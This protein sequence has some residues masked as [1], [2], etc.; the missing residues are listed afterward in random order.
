MTGESP[1]SSITI[2]W[3]VSVC[4]L[5]LP[6]S[7]PQAG[8]EGV[9]ITVSASPD[10]VAPDADATSRRI[11]AQAHFAAGATL[12]AQGAF[13]KALEAYQRA[14][15]AD[16]VDPHL[17]T[18]I[19]EKYI[20][21]Q[22]FK[23]AYSILRTTT[24][25]EAAPAKSFELLGMMQLARGEESPSVE[26]FRKALDLDATLILARQSLVDSH[27]REKREEAA[28][29]L[30]SAAVKV[31]TYELDDMSAL[32]GLYLKYTALRPPRVDSLAH[33]LESLLIK[34]SEVAEDYPVLGV[35]IADILMLMGRFKE[36]ETRLR[37]L[38]GFQ[39][40]IPMIR[41]KLVDLFLRQG[42]PDMAVIELVELTEINPD[43]PRPHFLLGSLKADL[44]QAG[45]A[46]RHYRKAMEVQP[47]FPAPYYELAALQLNQGNA[48]EALLVLQQAR[49]QFPKNFVLEFYSGLAMAS[50]HRYTAALRSLRQAEELAQKDDP[51]RLNGFFYFRIGSTL[52]RLGRLE[53]AETAFLQCLQKTPN[54]ATALNYLGYMWAEKGQKLD[55]AQAWIEKAFTMEPESEAILDSMGWVLFQQGKASE[56]LPFLEKAQKKLKEADPTILDHLGDVYK[57][58]E[59][60]E[61]ARISYQRSLE[62]EFN[63]KVFD[64]W[65]S[66]PE[67]QE[68]QS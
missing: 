35:P 22:R 67:K 29:D 27:L 10:P 31:S 59:Q 68:I 1:L 23:E 32:I 43:N 17:A 54:D 39:P 20:M 21:R 18:R 8:E 49:I 34:S 15:E 30:V 28:F 52:E 57:A 11:Q 5:L 36:A 60:H 40:P 62:I 50:L 14:L 41:E 44:G 24:E 2:A 9:G 66:L 19:A 4:A 7:S 16:P 12:E 48:R 13:D 53:E 47:T 33:Q 51:R 38:K 6:F 65:R 26:S 56:A 46:E 55:Q 42:Q 64:K 63:E 61:K 58:L 37:D 25:L 45:E 3:T